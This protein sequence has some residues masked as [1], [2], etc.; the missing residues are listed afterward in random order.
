MKNK[1]TRCLLKSLDRG[2]TCSIRDV[3][4]K[5]RDKER[6]WYTASLIKATLSEFL[7]PSLVV[8]MEKVT[9]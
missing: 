5:K 9:I 2:E 7:D 4:N 8:E 6:R 3:E 1:R